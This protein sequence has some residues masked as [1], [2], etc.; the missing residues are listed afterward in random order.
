MESES[1]RLQQRLQSAVTS[2]IEE[3]DREKFRKLRRECTAR[4]LGCFDNASLTMEQLDNCLHQYNKP[5]E[6]AQKIMQNELA[7]FQDRLQ[8][9]GTACQDTV[10]DKYPRLQSNS[11]K[12]YEGM[13]SLFQLL[14]CLLINV[15]II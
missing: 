8:R 10:Q 11:G 9:C 1:N 14:T 2:T 12:D 7:K 3:I 15:L 6:V 4:S 13:T 5:Q